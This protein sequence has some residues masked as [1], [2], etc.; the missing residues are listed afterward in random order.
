MYYPIQKDAVQS[1]YL[2]SNTKRTQ[3]TWMTSSSR[4]HLEWSSKKKSCHLKKVLSQPYSLTIFIHVLAPLL[5]S[6]N[7]IP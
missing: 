5:T 3:R 1:A 7:Q 4:D 6:M 2:Y